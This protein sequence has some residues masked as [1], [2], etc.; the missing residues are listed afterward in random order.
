[1]TTRNLAFDQLAVFVFAFDFVGTIGRCGSVVI[2]T[3]ATNQRKHLTPSANKLFAV[4][5]LFRSREHPVN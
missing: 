3:C 4:C 1:M 5:F 2:L